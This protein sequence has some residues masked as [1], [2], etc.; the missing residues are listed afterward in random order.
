MIGSLGGLLGSMLAGAVSAGFFLTSVPIWMMVV[1]A[2]VTGV[3]AQLG[4]LFESMMKR[5]ANRKDSGSIMPGHGGVL[6]RLDGVLFGAPIVLAGA[7]L[8]EK[9][10]H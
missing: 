3:L 5:I 1:L 6:D 7:L 10:L 4:D 9:I 2:L 8:I